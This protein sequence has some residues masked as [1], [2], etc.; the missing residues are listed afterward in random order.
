[1]KISFVLAAIAL[2]VVMGI[3]LLYRKSHLRAEFFT[4]TS[5][6]LG[7]K[8]ISTKYASGLAGEIDGRRALILSSVRDMPTMHIAYSKLQLYL[9]TDI[10]AD[11]DTANINKDLLARVP[12]GME[13]RSGKSV[14]EGST[15]ELVMKEAH[16]AAWNKLYLVAVPTDTTPEAISKRFEEMSALVSTSFSSR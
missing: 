8:L 6:A 3:A 11:T 15:L 13:L 2:A 10:P 9:E 7:F 1:M 4:S 12:E 5:D 16:G 14:F